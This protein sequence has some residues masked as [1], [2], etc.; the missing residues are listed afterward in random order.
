[1][2]SQV[3]SSAHVCGACHARRCVDSVAKHAEAG[4]LGTNYS[5]ADGARRDADAKT[6]QLAVRPPD[7]GGGLRSRAWVGLRHASKG[8][9]MRVAEKYT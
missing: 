5:G 3:H 2:H 6:R 1:M 7:L 8:S 4:A 9:K